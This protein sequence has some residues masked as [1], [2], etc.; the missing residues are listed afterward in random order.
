MRTLFLIAAALAVLPNCRAA[1]VK[2]SK[3]PDTGTI[4]GVVKFKGKQIPAKPINM[5]ADPFCVKYYK[6]KK[7]P[8]SQRFVWG[9]NST[10]QNVVVYVS[11]GL[12]TGRKYQPPQKLAE[13]K[14]QGCMYVPHVLVVQVNQKIRVENLDDTLHNSRSLPR[15]NKEY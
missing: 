12:P 6:D 10:L 13:L 2:L 9:R 5:A 14:Q 8:I 1:D 4:S 15:E 11:K 7:P 3:T